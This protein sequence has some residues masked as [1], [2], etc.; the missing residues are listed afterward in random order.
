MDLL[1]YRK[2]LLILWS[3]ELSSFLDNSGYEIVNHL[4]SKEI[5]HRYL[6]ET[7]DI[8]YPA[9]MGLCHGIVRKT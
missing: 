8:N 4:K 1:E 6:F 9:F 5:G 3:E 2:L 7:D